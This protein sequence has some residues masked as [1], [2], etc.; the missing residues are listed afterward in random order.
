[1]C[2]LYGA[3]LKFSIIERFGKVSY[4]L[5]DGETSNGTDKFEID[6][7]SGQITAKDGCCEWFEGSMYRVEVRA[8]DYYRPDSSSTVTIPILYL[9]YICTY[10]LH[11]AINKFPVTK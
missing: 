1:M 11:I 3:F 2:V 10:L 9:F 6:L 8:I 5:I 4:R 7:D